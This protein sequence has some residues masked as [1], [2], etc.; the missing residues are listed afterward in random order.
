MERVN[1]GLFGENNDLKER[2]KAGE[3]DRNYLITQL[4]AVKKDNV[5]LSQEL[6]RTDMEI[7]ELTEL[8]NNPKARTRLTSLNSSAGSRTSASSE[9]PNVDKYETNKAKRLEE[10][11]RLKRL[12]ESQQRGLRSLRATY[13]SKLHTRTELQRFLKQCLLDIRQQIKVTRAV[14]DTL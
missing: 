7:K 6:E 8:K 12:L 13:A 5:R 11:K 9:L 3:E 14:S 1:K 10:I 4:V 2:I